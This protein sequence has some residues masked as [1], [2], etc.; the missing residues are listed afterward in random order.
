MTGVNW[1]EVAAQGYAVPEGLA[2]PDALDE[3]LGMLGSE[4]PE[5]RDGQAYSTLATWTRAGYFDGVLRALGNRAALGLGH[6]SILVRSFS[7]LVLGEVVQRDAQSPNVGAAAR[8]MWLEHWQ[9]SYPYEQDVRSHDPT[10]GW[11]HV[12]AHGADTARAFALHPATTTADLRMILDTLTERLRS[13]PLHLNQTE[14]DRLAL[15]MLAVLT[16]PEL[17]G[18]DIQAWLTEYQTLWTP[19]AYPLAP[20]PALAIRTLHS[21]HTLLHLGATVDG[22][23]LR[24]AHPEPTIAV[25]QDALGSIYPYYGN[26][27]AG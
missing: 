18:D 1:A 25:V 7:A 14:D 11:I 15:A 9:F 3:L 22:V 4:N 24:P 6:E 17:G 10:L 23:T 13:L 27:Q 16:R 19:P 5:V 26:G 21:L 20:G 8:H 12:V 2:P